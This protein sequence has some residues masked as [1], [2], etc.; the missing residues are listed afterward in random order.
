MRYVGIA[1]IILIGLMVR[2][3]LVVALPLWADERDS[4]SYMELPVSTIVSGA[5]NV[6]H[7]PGY[8]LF[9]KTWSAVIRSTSAI[10]LRT[11]TLVLYVVN[12]LL[13]Y[14]LGR[15]YL[16][17]RYGTM[18]LLAYS[19]SGYSVIFDWQIRPYTALVTLMLASLYLLTLD[20]SLPVL[21]SFA[22]VHVVGLFLD[23]GFVWYAGSLCCLL[24]LIWMLPRLQQRVGM[25]KGFL[26]PLLISIVVYAAAWLPYWEIGAGIRGI[27]WIQPYTVPSF[28]IPYFLGAAHKQEFF[29]LFLSLLCIGGSVL[30]YHKKRGWWSVPP[31]VLAALSLYSTYVVNMLVPVLH[32]RNLQIVGIGLLFLYA[33]AFEWLAGKWKYVPFAI[34]FCLYCINTAV[35]V[36]YHFYAPGM[37]IIKF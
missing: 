6:T 33:A 3:Y 5:I 29:V 2:M 21:I 4:V 26:P 20:A 27:A 8:S 28:F 15:R 30:L 35:I 9:L 23:Y 36:Q 31:V 24:L 25:H 12:A 19:V 34:V 32:V 14:A 11:S 1:L 16:S 17:E 13:L 37:L 22:I 7:P 18:L 10:G